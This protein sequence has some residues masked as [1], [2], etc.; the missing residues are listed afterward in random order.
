MSSPRVL[1]AATPDGFSPTDA[2]LSTALHEA[3]ASAL[4][5]VACGGGDVLERR[6]IFRDP[7]CE[8]APACVFVLRADGF[9]CQV[10][11]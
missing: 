2:G 3:W 5:E 4:D 6:R 7:P 11:C 10:V 8:V 1:L 9:E